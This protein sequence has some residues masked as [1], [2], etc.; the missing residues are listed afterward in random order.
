MT[1]RRTIVVLVLL[2]LSPCAW[3]VGLFRPGKVVV[4]YYRCELDGTDQPYSAWVPRTYDPKTKWPLVIQLH[5]LGGNYRMGNVR[6]ELEDCI[7]VNPDGR[8]ATDYKLWGELDIVRV[9]EDARKRYS[10]DDNRVY[11]YGVSMGGSGSWQLGVHYPDLFAA[12]GPVCGNADHRVWE[13]LWQWGD[14]RNPTW[15]S[16]KKRWVESTESA[17]LYAENLLHLPAWCIH[18]DRDNVV[19]C[20][21]SRSM[22]AAMRQA[23]CKV[24]FDE[25]EGAGHGVPGDRF[26]PMIEWMKQQRRNPWPKRVVF[27]TAWRRHPGAYWVRIHRFAHGFADARVEAEQLGK[28]SVRVET[29]NVESFSLH[30]APPLFDKGAPIRVEVNGQATEHKAGADGWL[31]LRKQGDAW[32]PSA[33]PAGLHKTPEL[34][35]P[36]THAF[37]QGFLIVFGTQGDD[38]RAKR[39]TRDEANILK[40]RWNR[41]A[42]GKARV[43][44]DRDVK[45][46]DIESLNLILVGTPECNSLIAR[47]NGKLP[48]RIEDDAIAFGDKRFEG[49]DVGVKMVYPNPLNPKRYVALFS[50]ATWRGVYQIVG[51]FGNWFDWG[52]LDGWHWQDFAIFDNHSY[53][54]ETFLAVGYFDN[55]WRIHP[56]WHVVGDEKLRQA[57]PPRNTPPHRTPPEGV[58]R[59]YL[60]ELEPVWVRPEK[61][62]VGRDRS[63]NARPL[64]L[65]GRT[66]ERGLGVHPNCDIA[67][68]LG[69]RFPTF[70][71]VVGSDLEGEPGV[72]EARDRAESFEFMVIG[73]GKMMYQTGRMRWDHE[74]RHIYVPIAGVRRLELKIHRRSGPRWLSGPVDWAIAKVGEP[75][76]NQIAVRTDFQPNERLV[77]RRPLD[78]TWKLAGFEVGTGITRGAHRAEA[79]ALAGAVDAPVPGSVLAALGTADRKGATGK[80]WWYWRTFDVPKEWAGSSIWIEMDGAA[81]QADCW[82]NGRWVGRTVGPFVRGRLDATQ[83]AKLGER[84]TLA[85]RVVAS[86]A[87]WAKGGQPFRPAP[88]ASLVTS[89]ALARAGHPPLG[90]WQPIRLAS[91]GPC[92][93]R[94]LHVETV[95]LTDAEARLRVAADVANVVPEKLDVVLQIL[96][97]DGQALERKLAIGGGES[98]AVAFDVRLPKPRLW[99]PHGLGGQPLYT[100]RAVLEVAGNAVSD[101]RT[102]QFGVRTVA[103]DTASPAAR[104]RINGRRTV[105]VRGA[106]WLPADGLLR[107]DAARYRRLLA[108]ARDGGFNTLRVWGGGL[109]ETD[110]FYRLCD[111]AGL[112]VLQELPL[113]SAE[114][115]GGADDFLRNCTETILRLRSHPSLAAWCVGGAVQP[116]QAPDPRLT[117]EVAALCGQLDPQRRLVAD[118]PKTGQAQIWTTRTDPA[119]RRVYWRGASVAYTAGVASPSMARTLEGWLGRALPWPAAGQWPSSRAAGP[120]SSAR[121]HI[122]KAQVAQAAALGRILDRRTAAPASEVLWQLNEPLPSCSPALVD[123]AGTPKPAYYVLRRARAPLVVFADTGREMPATVPADQPLRAEICVRSARAPL[124]GAVAAAT[125]LDSRLR[126]LASWRGPADAR[127]GT[128]ARPLLLDWRPDRSLVGDVVFLHLRLHDA[129][130]NR[131]ASRLYWLG[132]TRPAEAAEAPRLRVG[133]LTGRPRGVLADQAFLAAAGIAVETPERE[134]PEPA[135]G[136]ALDEDPDEDAL[137]VEPRLKLGGYDVLVVDAATVLDDYTDSD[138]EAVAEAVA[139][140]V[141]LLID[142]ESGDLLVSS[143]EPAVPLGYGAAVATGV[144]RRPAAAE[145]GHPVVRGLS[146]AGCPVLARRPAKGLRRGASALVELDAT[147]P[148]A[149]EARH[150]RGRVVQLAGRFAREMAAWDEVRRFHA[151]LLGYLACLPHG[152]LVA[153]AD[154]AEPAPLAGLDR[155]GRAYVEAA[156]RQED[157]AAVVELTNPSAALAFMVHLDAEPEKATADAAPLLLSDNFLALFPGERRTVR[158]ARD[159]AAPV[160]DGRFRIVLRGWNLSARALDRLVVLREGKLSLRR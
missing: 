86:P 49:K 122:L 120:A 136:A 51:R 110:A 23:G 149:A 10:V 43:K 73:D 94:G 62:V 130:G 143:L 126:P 39:V 128:V 106:V 30:L 72:S 93:L 4:H 6:R 121:A 144:A 15:M 20:D 26:P 100:L 91:A 157:D 28:R 156:I 38:E 103:L 153:L 41:W 119:T 137:T 18:G 5:G 139:G 148:L 66:Y 83:G 131:L 13:K 105:D 85:V 70:E 60:S 135:K 56:A 81:Y 118:S 141:G 97:G 69:G 82:L 78:G 89:Q 1:H 147:H 67:F 33:E 25:V 77:E 58:G 71:A 44:A 95:E 63:F 140:G 34:E 80:E 154:A 129:A 31:R 98:Q 16:P 42:R 53:S 46:E 151:A 14:T 59:L 57:R 48:I 123:A 158:I 107:L 125:I 124:A 90:L 111:Q 64:T 55:D 45:P 155:L 54:P 145:P 35:G 127:P 27:K 112:L 99:W 96:I 150:G 152:G 79:E 160:T 24:T 9:L 87:E 102:V 117:A 74:P 52:I 104:L 132:V 19:P 7:V 108:R 116:G 3:A 113:T 68:D 50:G 115:T 17:A 76:H 84:N 40:D 114:Q 146:F 12:L 11:L 47:V 134:A 2:A 109:A 29:D 37:M 36:I 75:L 22:V 101:E 21:H 159:P 8:G 142:G 32:K 65:G 92:L 138:L 61:G 133:W 88:A